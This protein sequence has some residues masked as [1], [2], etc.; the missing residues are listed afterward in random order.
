MVAEMA[1]Q[2]VDV[3]VLGTGAAGMVAALSAHDAGAR[4]AIFEKADVIG[5]TT[6]LSG[7]VSW[8]PNNKLAAAAGLKDSREDGVAYL[9][10]LS[11]GHIPEDLAASFVDN[12][13][14]VLDYL[15]EKTP[16]RFHLLRIP[17]YHPEHPG[18]MGKGGRSLDP[19]LFSFKALGAWSDRIGIGQF[20]DPVTG[21][22]YGMTG[23]SPRG[24]GSGQV[25]EKEMARRREL[26]MNG[27]GR[28]MIGA[29]LAACL[30]RGFEP[31]T[32][33]RGVDLVM[34]RGRVAGVVI[35]KAGKR[36][37]VKCS[38][39]ILATGGFEWDEDMAAAYLRGPM[40]RPASIPTNTGDGQRMAMRAGARMGNMR[41]AWWMPVCELP[42]VKQYGEQ[43]VVLMLRE[44]TLPGSIM[45]NRKGVRFANEAMN[46][47]AIGSA[48]HIFD[49]VSFTYPNLPAWIIFDS[50]MIQRYGFLHLPAGETMPDWVPSADTP[51]ALAERIGCD[52][53]ALAA[54]L[55][56]WNGMVAKGSDDDFK[57][58]ESAY[59]GFN[60][61]LTQYP[62]KGATLG[63]I[64]KPPYYALEIISST[65]GTKG[66]PK[67][68]R[69]GAVLG[70]DGHPI[71]G[72]YAAGNAMAGPTGM[73]YGGAGGTLGP[74]IVFGYLA[75][76][77]AAT[78]I[79][80]RANA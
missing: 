50:T 76:R 80:E 67:T 40:R 2:E 8:L 31:V 60:G 23:E 11:N 15:E 26:L 33:A 59:D 34:E 46:Y 63:P 27:R 62:G 54:T 29:L 70:E 16:L 78:H 57:R 7:G 47:N 77:H 64:G 42:G 28:G 44:R 75:G 19:S 61:D 51:E 73:V 43:K 35:E 36:E 17:D 53:Q 38:S 12:V 68:D 22:V 24:G 48:F 9:R 3:V 58:G 32:G 10:S 39:V 13:Q 66:G 72:L 69:D 52:G 20:S 71:P 30:E 65:L 21:H 6:A 25:D 4:V 18:G 37:T 45:V 14:P 49:P 74:A 5:G 55:K 56:R 1:G 41:E 79:V